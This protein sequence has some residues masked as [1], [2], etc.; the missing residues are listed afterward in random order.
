MRRL[1]AIERPNAALALLAFLLISA[2]MESATAAT[3]PAVP[4]RQGDASTSAK[5]YASFAS[6]P[7]PVRFNMLA[8]MTP[9]MPEQQL[10]TLAPMMMGERDVD[11]QV[12][13]EGTLGRNLPGRRFIYGTGIGDRLYVWYESGGIAHM[14]HLAVYA[15]IGQRQP[16]LLN[17]FAAGSLAM[18]CRV[19]EGSTKIPENDLYQKFW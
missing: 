9:E 19:L 15:Q 18:L 1:G 16:K 13:D 12:T 6:L 4:C 17:H 5:P 14:Y 11:W 7:E 10:R 3:S 8:H 2:G